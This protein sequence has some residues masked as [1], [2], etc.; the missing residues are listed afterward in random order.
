MVLEGTA[1]IWKMRIAPFHVQP[2]DITSDGTAIGLGKRY[3]T[4]HPARGTT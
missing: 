2:V 3:V 1:I 4:E